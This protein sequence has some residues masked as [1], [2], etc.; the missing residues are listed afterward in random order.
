MDR[1]G[2]TGLP[3]HLSEITITAPNNDE[4]GQK[5]QAIIARNLYRLWFSI[6]PMMGITWWNVVDDCGAPGEPSVSGLFNRDMTP[7]PAYFVMNDLINKEWKT[8]LSLRPNSNGDIRFRGFK[9]T[10]RI[11]YTNVGGELKTI[12]YVLK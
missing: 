10:Y 2:S 1:L 12:D 7:K 5:I 8:V 4:R 9:G 6:E 3:I 11:S